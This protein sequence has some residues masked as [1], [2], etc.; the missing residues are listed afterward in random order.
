MQLAITVLGEKSNGFLGEILSALSACQC[1]VLELR[2]SNLTELTAAYLLIDGN[3]NH[4][5]KLEGMLDAIK[6]RLEIQMS[7]LRPSQE[8]QAIEGV[9]YTL[10]TISVDKNDIL[11]AVT[12][13]LLDRGICIEEVSASRHSAAFFNTSVFSTKFILLVP[14]AVRIL[15]LREEFLDFCDSLNIDAILE[16][17]KR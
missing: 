3:W 9:P 12:S 8:P 2:T 10:E 7:F 1:N 5:A 17:V 15:S 13:F 6:I 14:P 16:P 11:F 4:I